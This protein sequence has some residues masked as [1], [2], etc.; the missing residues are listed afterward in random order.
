V[1]EASIIFKGISTELAS[2]SKRI[3]DNAVQ[4]LAIKGTNRGITNCRWDLKNQVNKVNK[5]LSSITKSFK[6]VPSKWKLQN[7]AKAIDD[8]MA[9][10]HEVNTRLTTDME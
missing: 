8:Q 3:M 10:I 9:W 7:T 6:E 5:V 4:F 1:E 2:L